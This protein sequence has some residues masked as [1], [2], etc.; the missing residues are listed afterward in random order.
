MK[1]KEEARNRVSTIGM[2]LLIVCLC[3]LSAFLG[4]RAGK[5]NAGAAADTPG[6]GSMEASGRMLTM[7]AVN[8]PE[9]YG[10]FTPEELNGNLA[11]TMFYKEVTDVKILIGTEWMALPDAIREGK[12]TSA[13]MFYRARTD[14]ANGF[15][16]EKANSY[17]GLST[18]V[19]SYPG[20]LDLFFSYD[21][22]ETPDGGQHLIDDLWVGRVNTMDTY[23]NR[24]KLDPETGLR[25]DREDWGLSFR[26]REATPT[27]MTLEVTQSG[28]QQ[29]GELTVEAFYVSD[30]GGSYVET[31]E[32]E[33]VIS[34]DGTTELTLD[35]SNDLGTL[36]A[37]E[38]VLELTIWDIYNE[39]H[40]LIVKY[41]D[42]QEYEVPFTVS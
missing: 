26:V 22:Y 33:M 38:Y 36:P 18:F 1:N 42:Y 12:I 9:K 8:A 29:V 39:C 2:V 21:V 3:L 16:T 19:F 31:V 34:R 40:P 35:W 15:C 13:E 23:S 14:A 32:S 7:S 37:G 6:D 20:E 25:L 5:D 10:F 27:G 11:D 24:G 28:G 30:A 17:N 41:N 4:F